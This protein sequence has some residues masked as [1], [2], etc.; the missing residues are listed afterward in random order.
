MFDVVWLSRMQFAITTLYHFLFVPLTL[1]LSIYIALF[2]TI[3]HV[4]KNS[5][6]Q[7]LTSFF[8]KLFIINFSVA[9]WSTPAEVLKRVAE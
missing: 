1:G 9:V 2:E 8:A 5:D 7:Q 4:K 3:T 6:Y